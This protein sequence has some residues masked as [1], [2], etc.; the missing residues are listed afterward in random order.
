MLVLIQ[1]DHP[2]LNIHMHICVRVYPARIAVHT[3]TAHVNMH[4]YIYVYNKLKR[5][6]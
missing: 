1:L 5:L 6:S 2:V 3:Y 4:V